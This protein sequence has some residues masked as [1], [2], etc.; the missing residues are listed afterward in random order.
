MTSDNQDKS[1]AL[2]ETLK[3]LTI[4]DAGYYESVSATANDTKGNTASNPN[5]YIHTSD[6]KN[7]KFSDTSN[8]YLQQISIE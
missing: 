5:I 3:G 1:D 6:R 4:K 2:A 8:G 7:I